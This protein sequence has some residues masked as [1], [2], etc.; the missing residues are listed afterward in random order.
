MDGLVIKRRPR[1]K[2]PYLICAWPGMGDVAFQ[3]AMHLIQQLKAEEFA[4]ILPHE[5]FFL[6]SSS[7]QNG[8]LEAPDLPYSKFFFYKRPSGLNAP[9]DALKSN[10]PADLII[11]VSSGQPDLTKAEE[12]SRLI[13][14]LAKGFKVKKVIGFAAMP[15]PIDYT[16]S[17]KVWY[18]ATSQKIKK[19][20]SPY[21]LI[22]LKEG[23]ISGM[24]GLFLG[25]A[26]RQGL[27]GFCL[28]GEIPFYT[29]QIENPRASQAIL[30]VL[31]NI[32]NLR[33]DFMALQKQAEFIEEEIS[34]LMDY[35]KIGQQQE[36]QL[37]PIGEE[38]IERI[39]KSLSQ[40]TRLPVSIRER[41]EKLF[42]QARQDLS[43]AHE[44]KAELDKWSVYKEYEDR[45][46][47]LFKKDKDK[48]N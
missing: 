24:N 14:Q 29:I 6:N 1:L 32:L 5:F 16:Q 23:Q 3:A 43:R 9:D 46:L 40:L 47:D 10:L 22:E 26:K 38:E 19:E 7:I 21:N 28:L 4:E 33:L 30:E 42:A 11:F 35:L 41:I 45:F 37:P 39:K 8:V 48:N 44:L 17:P 20:L 13:I 18:A 36:G 2:N 15:Q 12:Y 34:R 31:A 27:E 25:L